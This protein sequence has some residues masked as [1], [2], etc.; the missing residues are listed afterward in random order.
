MFRSKQIDFLEKLLEKELRF[1]TPLVVEGKRDKEALD[2]LG[3]GNTVAISGTPLLEVVD[4]IKDSGFESVGI[5]TDFDKEGERKASR[6]EMLFN[7]N[8]IKVDNYLREK[9]RTLKINEVEEL[10][11]L[12]RFGQI[13]KDSVAS[14]INSTQNYNKISNHLLFMKRKKAR[15]ARYPKKS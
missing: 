11:G 10:N 2:A 15:D 14:H 7:A 8:G 6:L 3:F 4:K 12:S 13:P 5:M 9:M 1:E